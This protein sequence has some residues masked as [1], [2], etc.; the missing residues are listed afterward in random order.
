MIIEGEGSEAGDRAVHQ[1]TLDAVN[2]TNTPAAVATIRR[3]LA[4]GLTHDQIKSTL[5]VTEHM[6]QAVEQG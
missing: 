6:I 4:M 1:P 5:G 3:G 2:F